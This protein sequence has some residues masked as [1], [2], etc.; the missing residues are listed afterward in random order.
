MEWM[1]S[2]NP[3]NRPK[4]N[5]VLAHAFF[6][7]K[8]I[9]TDNKI[10]LKTPNILTSQDTTAESKNRPGLVES[11]VIGQ[12]ALQMKNRVLKNASQLAGGPSGTKSD[13][14]PNNHSPPGELS[15]QANHKYK[16]I[17]FGSEIN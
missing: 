9:S 16:S 10:N 15:N 6:H 5:Q 11:L 12:N 2:Y 1:L 8:T 7:P 4:P 3:R 13:L 14:L 17:D